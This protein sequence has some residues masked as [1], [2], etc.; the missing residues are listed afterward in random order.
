M[1]QLNSIGLMLLYCR[2]DLGLYIYIYIYICICIYIYIYIYIYISIYMSN[3]GL[4][5][6]IDLV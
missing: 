1:I 5:S 3:L 6:K 4:Y 2:L